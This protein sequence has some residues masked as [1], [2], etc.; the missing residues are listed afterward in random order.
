MEPAGQVVQPVIT[1]EEFMARHGIGR[2]LDNI[3][4]LRAMPA[5][6]IATIAAR[7]TWKLYEKHQ[8][9][10]A[11][12]DS[13]NG[14]L[15]VRHGLVRVV[16]YSESGREVS[17][18]DIGAGGHFGEIAAIDGGPRSAFVVA[19]LDTVVAM[20]AQHDF[21]QLVRENPDFAHSVMCSLTAII[22]GSNLKV[23]DL[24]T[25]K[26][27]DRIIRE[28]V[29]L[30]RNLGEG[31]AI[32]RVI[33]RPAPT[34]TEIASRAA[35]TRETVARTFADLVRRGLIRRIKTDLE[36]ISV[37]DLVELLEVTEGV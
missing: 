27:P 11:Q 35:T 19:Q 7:C 13:S 4:L 12:D 1:L 21:L 6:V 31:E 16:K 32:D 24:S 9:I 3:Q 10:L 28:L 22:R 5:A 33:I 18:A 34:A 20:L 30:A 36:L 17:Y 23:L 37:P 29:R 2:T 26:A 14:V 25:L 15:L 8:T